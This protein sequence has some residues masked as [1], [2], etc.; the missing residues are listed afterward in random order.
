MMYY[1]PLESHKERYT[2]QWSAPKTG[3]LER[4]W[5]KLNISYK[6][7]EGKST[8]EAIKTGQVLDAIGRSIWAFSQI[9]QLLILL[10]EG[11]IKNSDSIYFDDFWH[12]GIEALPYA[13]HLFNIHPSMFAFC[14]AQSVDEFDFTY[15]MRHWMRH[16]EKG[17]AAALTGIF[18]N[19]V[20]LKDL[21]YLGGVCE[22]EKIHII[23]HIFSSEE[24]RER[25]PEGTI[26]E[27]EN[28]IIF[29]SRWD[30]EKN[31]GFF[32]KVAVEVIKQRPKA[33]FVICTS[34]NRLKSN[35]QMLIDGLKRL[36]AEY[37]NNIILKEGLTKEEYYN[38]L[39]R[40]KIQMN[41]ANQDFISICLLEA[42]VAGCYPIYPYFRSFPEAFNYDMSFMY[43]HLNLQ[44][45]V[46]KVIS[47]LDRDDLWTEEEID[48][49]AWIHLRHDDSWKNMLKVIWRK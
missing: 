24:V 5:I 42:S 17:I 31:P 41:T 48:K 4:N 20:C 19:S 29:S 6:R 21:L 37:P 34:F 33:E 47:I 2:M 39:C 7:I 32:M 14:H 49:R 10:E 9:E 23:G 36:I 3:W 11:I 40:A 8:G 38:E 28:K 13:F 45:A 12:P 46:N 30:V 16:F 25:M 44:S 43:E 18:V 15:P 22:R 1:C 35:N 27:R 26:I